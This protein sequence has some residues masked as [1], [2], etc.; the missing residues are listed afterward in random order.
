MQAHRVEC[1]DRGLQSRRIFKEKYHRMRLLRRTLSL[2]LVASTLGLVSCSSL[3][4]TDFTGTNGAQAA[5]PT[6]DQQAT[7]ATSLNQLEDIAVKG[8][9]P[10][11]GYSREQ[12]SNGW[13]DTDNNGCDARND[14]L[15]RD[16]DNVEYKPARVDCV[17]LS[18]TFHDPYTGKAINFERGQSTSSAVQID[19]VVALSDAWQKGAQKWSKDERLQFANDPLNLLASDGPTNAAKGD[20][21][22]AT[23]LPPNKDFRC[24]Y[25]SRQTQVKAKYGAWMTQAEHDSIKKILTSCI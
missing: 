23:W 1:W 18:G 10:K 15:A 11:T 19:H 14:I 3:A 21:D 20:K 2:V 8:R 13:K 12:F 24:E 4:S 7:Y 17:V 5:T 25:V 9:A 22:A 16:L 6:A